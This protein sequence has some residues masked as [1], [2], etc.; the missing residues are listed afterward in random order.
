MLR[1]VTPSTLMA[2]VR[3]RLAFVQCFGTSSYKLSVKDQVLIYGSMVIRGYAGALRLFDED[4]VKI[5]EV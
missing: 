5:F 4:G 3:E 1:Y 2:P